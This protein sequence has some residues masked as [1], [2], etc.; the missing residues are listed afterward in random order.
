[1]M[2]GC[3]GGSSGN[4]NDDTTTDIGNSPNSASNNTGNT[5]P[6]TNLEKRFAASENGALPNSLNQTFA[7]I[8]QVTAE[9]YE[10]EFSPS[11][12]ATVVNQFVSM[13]YQ[14]NGNQLSIDVTPVFG[15]GTSY[16]HQR[17][18]MAGELMIGFVGSLNNGVTSWPIACIGARHSFSDATP[19]TTT[20]TCHSSNTNTT[21]DTSESSTNRFVL[22][23]SHYAERHFSSRSFSG[24]IN[25]SLNFRSTSPIQH[26]TYLYDQATGDFVMAFM[27]VDYDKPEVLLLD[28]S[29]Q[30]NGES[31][32]VAISGKKRQCNFE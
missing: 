29:G 10:L 22:H 16:T 8:D 20:I 1:M 26:G 4:G 9:F 5:S 12:Q 23:P 30:T 14:L 27:Y 7:C 13:N 6:V 11:G 24:G 32:H 15:A 19:Q 28:F 3:G 31:V 21:S 25:G 2:L 18:V 17:H